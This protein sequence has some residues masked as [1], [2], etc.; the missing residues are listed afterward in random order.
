MSWN[1]IILPREEAELDDGLTLGDAAEVR[2]Q[3]EASLS[4]VEWAGPEEGLAQGPGFRIEISLQ[5]QGPVESFMLHITGQGE[6]LPVVTDLCRKH[7]WA[8]FDSVAG[9]YIDI[10]QPSDAGWRGYHAHIS[11]KVVPPD[12]Q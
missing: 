1:L 6:P 12:E 8:L 5:A 9:D 7:G 3:L 4:P 10:A 2:A 11:G